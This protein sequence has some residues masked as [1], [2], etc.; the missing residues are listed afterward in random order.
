MVIGWVKCLKNMRVHLRFWVLIVACVYFGYSVYFAWAGLRDSLGMLTNSYI[1]SSLRQDPWWW[2]VSFYSSEGVSG[3]V[4]IV[5]RAVAGVFAVWAAYLFWR[6]TDSVKLSLRQ[7][8]CMAMLF[9]AVFLLAFIPSILTAIVYNSTS[10]QLFYFGHTPNILIILGTLIP[11]TGFV[12]VCTPPL[13]KLRFSHQKLRR[14]RRGH[15][16]GV[17]HRRGLPLRDVL[18]QLHHAVGWRSGA[19]HE[20]LRAVG[21]ELR[22]GT[23]QLRKLPA[24]RGRLVRFGCGGSGCDLP[25]D[26]EAGC[27]CRI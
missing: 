5:S 8:T 16:V 1:Y 21:M 15:E 12:V 17:P 22:A 23:R 10:Q 19:V 18:V 9:E 24:H 3:S 7:S 20:G 14:Q 2:L 25:C 13:L 6:K 27:R 11:L 26:Q 4:A